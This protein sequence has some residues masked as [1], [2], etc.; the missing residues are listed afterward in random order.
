MLPREEIRRQVAR[1][2]VRE[3]GAPAWSLTREAVHG[4][5]LYRAPAG[6]GSD[7]AVSARGLVPARLAIAFL[8][9]RRT[10]GSGSSRA[11]RRKAPELARSGTVSPSAHTAA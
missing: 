11:T 9:N 2:V 8:A 10:R 3:A 7:G 5:R 1:L 4:L 6:A